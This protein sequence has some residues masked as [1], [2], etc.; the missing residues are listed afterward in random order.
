MTKE[1]RIKLITILIQSARSAVKLWNK[2]ADQIAEISGTDR[3]LI[4]LENLTDAD[5]RAVAREL[6]REAE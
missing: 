4:L 6:C 2:L 5:A 3:E 1:Q